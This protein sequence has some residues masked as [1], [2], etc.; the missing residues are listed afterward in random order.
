MPI[1]RDLVRDL[2]REIVRDT[3]EEQNNIGVAGG[4]GFGVGIYPSYILPSGMTALAGTTD[5][6]S[7]NYGNYQY[8][9]GSVMCWVPKFYYKVGTG[10]NGLAVNVIDIKGTD[11]YATTALANAAGYAL[12]RA[13]IDGGVEQQGFF[14]DKYMASKTASGTGFKA[15]SVKNGLPIS[16]N[17]AHN[18]IADIT[19]ATA[20]GNI[21][22]ACLDA[23]K[24]RSGTNGAKDA[25]SPFFATSLFIYSALAMLATAHGQAATSTTNCAWYSATTTNFPKGCNNNALADTNDTAVKW[26]S[27]GYSNCGKTGSAGFGGGA[28]NLFAKST[29][30]GQNC[31]VADLNGLMYEIAPGMTA[32]TAAKTITAATQANPCQ[33][34]IAAHGYATGDYVMILS[35]VGMTQLNDKIY[36]ITKVDDNNFTLDGI[37]SSA[38]TAYS[39]GGTSTKGTFYALK[40]SVAMK[41]ITSGNTL[42][43]DHWGATGVAA[44]MD[45]ISMPLVAGGGFAQR[46]GNAANQVLSEAVNGAGYQLTGLGLPKDANGVSG[47]GTNL[48]G[49]DY[50]Y[51]YVRNELC[52]V[53]GGLWDNTTTAGV[54]CRYWA[55]IRSSSL[56]ATGF[57]VAAYPW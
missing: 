47:S 18:P 38:Y 33:I 35:V 30:N 13:F 7:D 49:T 26:E 31:G 25:S 2:A 37:D 24:G 4:A 16:T 19:A 11:T 3:T 54:W 10:S 21:Y 17:S 57:R 46:Y 51:Q 32:I 50:Y 23:A 20:T 14:V 1:V 43:T 56:Y 34:T 6:T 39:S 42:A 55:G 27:D 29:H 41:S 8:A 15:S 45:A 22:A 53:V 12:H 40:Q 5:K 36:Q 44:L 52:P 9:D 28:G 48:F